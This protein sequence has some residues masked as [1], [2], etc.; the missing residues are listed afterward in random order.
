MRKTKLTLVVILL[1]L[2]LIIG[3]LFVSYKKIVVKYS[4]YNVVSKI[5]DIMNQSNEVVL[6]MDFYYS[7]YFKISYDKEGAVQAVIANSGLINQL[8]MLWGTE[9]QNRLNAMRTFNV[10]MPSGAFTGGA[11]FANF[12]ITIPIK[13]QVVAYADIIYDSDFVSVGINQT[14]HTLSFNTKV[15]ATVTVPAGVKKIEVNQKVLLA[16][17]IINGKVPDTYLVETENGDYF[18]LLP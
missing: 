7:D 9:I 18:D 3:F 4:E 8:A 2:I 6:A 5:N 13:T 17:T 15:N 14:K 12:G 16:E 10:D 11:I 1:I